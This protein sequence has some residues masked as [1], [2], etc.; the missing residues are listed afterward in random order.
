MVVAEQ[1][2]DASEEE[3]GLFDWNWLEVIASS[4]ND[5]LYNE[6]LVSYREGF[7]CRELILFLLQEELGS[8][9]MLLKMVEALKFPNDDR[10]DR[11]LALALYQHVRQKVEE[12]QREEELDEIK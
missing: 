5:D 7:N 3:A 1:L 6:K 4:Q 11:L 9:K 10:R 2:E 12:E 8:R